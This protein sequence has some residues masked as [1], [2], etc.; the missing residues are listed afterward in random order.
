MAGCSSPG[1]VRSKF[2]HLM[3]DPFPHVG[4]LIQSLSWL[5]C[6]VGPGWLSYFRLRLGFEMSPS[7]GRCW[8]NQ[9]KNLDEGILCKELELPLLAR[10]GIT[11]SIYLERRVY[12][13]FYYVFS[14]SFRGGGGLDYL[15][16]G[17][18]F[19]FELLEQVMILF[20]ARI[21]KPGG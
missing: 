17:R 1:R 14:L 16:H 12:Y 4:W 10:S 5:R 3:V 8:T 7:V 13:Y 19:L 18:V 6:L 20:I 9:R 21:A 15:G 2:R 11:L